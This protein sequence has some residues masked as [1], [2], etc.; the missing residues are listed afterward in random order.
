MQAFQRERFA[1]MISADIDALQRM[2]ADDVVYTHTSGT[3]DTKAT[4]VDSIRTGRLRYESIEPRSVDAHASGA[5]AVVTGQAA[6]RV[7]SNG[8]PASFDIRFTEVDALRGGRWQLLAWQSTRVTDRPFPAPEGDVA[9]ARTA[10]QLPVGATDAERAMI[11]VHQ[12]LQTAFFAADLT[13][14]RHDLDEMWTMITPDGQAHMK[15]QV[16]STLL[17]RMPPTLQDNVR[18]QMQG[19]MAILT[20]R[21][22]SRG[23]QPMRVMIV[24]QRQPDGWR[25]IVHQ[26][27][28]IS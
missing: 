22:V 8:S 28:P 16:L 10:I 6:V 1:A 19:D 21:S 11:D 9:S 15:Q 26:Q 27:T 17:P 13:T 20:L 3:T 4:F 23:L 25:Q 2:L 14:L 7:R 18:V 24:W 12:R 5:I